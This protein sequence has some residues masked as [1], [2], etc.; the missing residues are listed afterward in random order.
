MTEAVSTHERRRSPRIA[1]RL[2]VVIYAGESSVSGTTSV[3]N[4]H[5]ALVHSPTAFLAGATLL[6]LN[7]A[8]GQRVKAWV[9][10]VCPS[11]HEHSSAL[12]V[13]FLEEA[14]TFWGTEYGS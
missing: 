11:E 14:G 3:I 5:G 10:R 13:E 1:R 9:V 12:S 6:L 8:T 4:A 7:P 2:T